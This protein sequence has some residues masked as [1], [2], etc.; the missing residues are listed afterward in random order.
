MMKILIMI[1]VACLILQNSLSFDGLSLSLANHWLGC[2]HVPL[3]FLLFVWCSIGFFVSFICSSHEP[4]WRVRDETRNW[5]FNVGCYCSY[6]LTSFFSGFQINSSILLQVLTDFSLVTGLFCFITGVNS[7][8][9]Y[10]A[11]TNVAFVGLLR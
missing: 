10:I 2:C 3:D 6:Q 5:L 1:V 8:F 9:P 11:V 4:N 7:F